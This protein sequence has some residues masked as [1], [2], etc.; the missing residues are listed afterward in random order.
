MVS[1]LVITVAPF[2]PR[3]NARVYYFRVARKIVHAVEARHPIRSESQSEKGFGSV[4]ACRDASLSLA[5]HVG[6]IVQR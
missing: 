5:L 6:R 4:R 2:Q 1:L 3:H